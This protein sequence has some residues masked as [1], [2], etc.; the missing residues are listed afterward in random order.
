MTAG[1]LSYQLCDRQFDC[2][3]CPLDAAMR[4]QYR[5]AES[6]RTTRAAG[7][8]SVISRK[9]LYFSTRHCWVRRQAGNLC[10]VGIE[11]G[12]AHALLTPKAIAFP[13]L[14]EQVQKDHVCLWIVTSGGTFP[15]ISPLS[16]RVSTVNARLTEEPHLIEKQPYDGGWVFEMMVEPNVNVEE[17][18]MSADEAAGKFE[19]NQRTFRDLLGRSLQAMRPIVGP[20]LADG[21][22]LLHQIS[23]MLGAK[24]YFDIVCEVFT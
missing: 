7:E 16:G 14:G 2:D 6:Q 24:K 9:D 13:A 1:L 22:A 20:T 12:L 18:L 19:L 11:A 10:R 21:G 15:V 3:N 4:K 5:P 8:E 23:D 17:E